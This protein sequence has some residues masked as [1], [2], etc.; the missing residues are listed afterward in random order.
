M[1]RSADDFEF[2]ICRLSFHPLVLCTFFRHYIF[3]S[4][5]GMVTS[6]LFL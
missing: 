4:K 1:S 2:G 5:L 6:R 3:F